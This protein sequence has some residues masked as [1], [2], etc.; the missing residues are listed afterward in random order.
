M[1]Q[2]LED[3][4]AATPREV[5]NAVIMN[6]SFHCSTILVLSKLLSEESHQG[7]LLGKVANMTCGFLEK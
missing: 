6:M 7:I 5:G 1:K 2:L 3:E 4:I